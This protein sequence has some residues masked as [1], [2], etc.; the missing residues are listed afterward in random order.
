ML[1]LGLSQTDIDLG[2]QALSVTCTAYNCGIPLNSS[3]V[4]CQ[5]TA[6]GCGASNPDCSGLAGLVGSIETAS[7]DCNATGSCSVVLKGLPVGSIGVSCDT[8][9]CTATS[10]VFNGTGSPEVDGP[11]M[12]RLRVAAVGFLPTAALLLVLFLTLVLARGCSAL[13]ACTGVDASPPLPVGHLAFSDL[14]VTV[15]QNKRQQRQAALS[16]SGP[17]AESAASQT[18]PNTNQPGSST[19]TSTTGSPYEPDFE[20]ARPRRPRLA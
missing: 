16:R 8:G 18:T 5:A 6:C 12:L 15:P 20:S 13:L 10:P 9:T 7:I 4:S 3:K 17:V 2:S 19:S 1:W 14:T 11:D